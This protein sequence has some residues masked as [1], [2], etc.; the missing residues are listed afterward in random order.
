MRPSRG[1]GALWR[2]D[3]KPGTISLH[4][5]GLSVRLVHLVNMTIHISTKEGRAYKLQRYSL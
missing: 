4:N 1:C 3:R 2:T 5:L